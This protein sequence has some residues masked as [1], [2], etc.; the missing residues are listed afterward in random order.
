MPYLQVDARYEKVREG[1][2]VIDQAALTAIGIDLEGHREMLGITFSRSEA[3]VHW[4]EFLQSLVERGPSG[5]ELIT[6]D[7]H[8]GLEADRKA[9]FPS[10]TYQGC[11][12][13]P[14]QNAS[15]YVV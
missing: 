14:Q 8:T 10:V 9:V 6:S 1:G 3:E 5:A 11:Q 13:H 7:S 15:Q 12:F 4:R 2:L